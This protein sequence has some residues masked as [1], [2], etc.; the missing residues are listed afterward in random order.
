MKKHL[1]KKKLS[2]HELAAAKS[3]RIESTSLRQIKGGIVIEEILG[4]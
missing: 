4:G 2:V 1:S 3:V